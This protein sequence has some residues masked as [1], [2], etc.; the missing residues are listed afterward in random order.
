MNLSLTQNIEAP[1]RR[2]KAIEGDVPKSQ[3]HSRNECNV[4]RI[5]KSIK[6]SL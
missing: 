3:I 5:A 1:D 6:I 2:A 4:Y